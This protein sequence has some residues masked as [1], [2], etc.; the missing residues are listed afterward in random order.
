MTI[1]I[2]VRLPDVEVVHMDTLVERGEIASRAAYVAKALERQRRREANERDLALLLATK[3]DPD[4]DDLD[5]LARWSSRQP[6]D[7]D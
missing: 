3:D 7:L 1:Q 2:T 4:P 5:G 6:L